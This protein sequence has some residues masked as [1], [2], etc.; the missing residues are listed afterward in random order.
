MHTHVYENNCTHQLYWYLSTLLGFDESGF[1]SIVANENNCKG[2]C[3]WEIT[4]CVNSAINKVPQ[5]TRKGVYRVLYLTFT[6][7]A[8]LQKTEIQIFFKIGEPNFLKWWAQAYIH[9]L[10]SKHKLKS[11]TTCIRTKQAK[12]ET[13]ADQNQSRLSAEC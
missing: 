6:R 11:I 5:Q 2:H 8:F 10:N 1:P 13:L 9:V 7:K 3:A 12:S 4:R